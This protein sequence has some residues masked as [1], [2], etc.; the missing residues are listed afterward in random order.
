MRWLTRYKNSVMSAS[1]EHKLEQ[2]YRECPNE[3]SVLDVG[4]S[5]ESDDANPSR[6]SFL[7]NFRFD[8]VLYTALGIQDL[9]DMPNIYPGYKF[10]TY[11]GTIF[12]FSDK[13]FDLVWSN[14]V[15]EHVGQ[16]DNQVRFV[17]EMLRVSKKC[18]FT[19]P[20]KYFPIETHTTVFLLHYYDYLFYKYLVYRSNYT[21]DTLSLLS[22]KSLVRVME[23]SNAKEYR[24]IRNKYYGM[25]MTF[26]II[27]SD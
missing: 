12:P 19:T 18:F 13:E 26:S 21:E 8:P 17:N 11:D 3:C 9:S 16:H 20:N 25:T 1:R 6:N 14:A 10:V 15:I 5:A 27:A 24:I 23:A 22:P 2:F 7:K 4:V